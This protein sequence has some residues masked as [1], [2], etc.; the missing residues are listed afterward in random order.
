MDGTRKQNEENIG[1]HIPKHFY[2]YRGVS[3]FQDL[4]GQVVHNAVCA[5]PPLP[6]GAFYAAKIWV[7]NCP[8]CPPATY[9]PVLRV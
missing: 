5:P 1:S 6:G 4:G 9:A 2:K 8:P 3:S 7:G